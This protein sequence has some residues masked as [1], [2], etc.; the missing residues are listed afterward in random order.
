MDRRTFL[1][2]AAISPMTIHH[3]LMRNL[4]AQFT[5]DD[6]ISV[7]MII[8]AHADRVSAEQWRAGWE[9]RAFEGE[10]EWYLQTSQT[11]DLPDRLA[12]LPGTLMYHT[13][14]IGYAAVE[15]SMLVGTFRRDHIACVI[16]VLGDN[17][18][19]M[20]DLAHLFASR[21]LPGR[22]ELL[23][24][25]EQLR[26]FIPTSEEFGMTIEPNESLWP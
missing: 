18:E 19:E 5:L 22:L 17:R 15:R 6:S 2:M 3:T 12:K 8:T 7:Q 10:G 4:R 13:F 1:T 21:P 25:G 16:R 20:I 23:W 14:V 9:N 24:S 26:L 11:L